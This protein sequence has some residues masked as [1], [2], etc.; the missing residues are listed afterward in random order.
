MIAVFE[1]FPAF[2]ARV[3]VNRVHTDSTLFSIELLGNHSDCGVGSIM[4]ASNLLDFIDD[5]CWLVDTF[6]EDANQ[7]HCGGFIHFDGVFSDI[8]E[9]SI[10]ITDMESLG[11]LKLAMDWL[12]LY[13]EWAVLLYFLFTILNRFQ[14]IADFSSSVLL[15]ISDFTD[16]STS[17]QVHVLEL[18]HL[19]GL[20]K[21]SRVKNLNLLICLF[22]EI[23][24]HLHL[25]DFLFD[26]IDAIN[27]LTVLNLDFVL[28]SDYIH[29][30]FYSEHSKRHEYYK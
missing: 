21:F 9:K 3:M 29:Y 30:N 19:I 24:E 17:L 8:H 5:G 11:V 1:R 16:S 28:N 25:L 15:L 23:T 18:K 26:V 7:S 13:K 22:I 6:S 2:F 27:F 12:N 20:G 4:L 14:F 10:V